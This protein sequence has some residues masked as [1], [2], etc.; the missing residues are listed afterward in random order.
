MTDVLENIEADNGSA[1]LATRPDF[2]I[3]RPFPGR[4][5]RFIL[6]RNCDAAKGHWSNPNNRKGVS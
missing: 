5:W 4:P 2:L 3:A 6:F 1:A